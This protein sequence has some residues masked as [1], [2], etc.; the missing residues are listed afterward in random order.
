MAEEIILR[1]NEDALIKIKEVILFPVRV[2]AYVIAIPIH[3]FA[4]TIET[5]RQ[6]RYDPE[7]ALCPGCGFKGDS[8]TNGKTC[9]IQHI[10]TSGPEKASNEHSCFRCG[11]KF[12]TPLFLVADKWAA[13]QWPQDKLKQAAQRTVL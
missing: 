8:G 13:K 3:V 6:K 1:S 11:A 5:L 12:Y 2:L 7:K 4:W 9:R 10:L